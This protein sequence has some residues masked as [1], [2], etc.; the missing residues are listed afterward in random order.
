MSAPTADLQA[1]TLMVVAAQEE[2]VPRGPIDVRLVFNLAID[3]TWTQRTGGKL[4]RVKS[5]ASSRTFG[6]ELHSGVCHNQ[7]FRPR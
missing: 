3:R 2:A 6:P 7:H 1:A 4:I 5:E